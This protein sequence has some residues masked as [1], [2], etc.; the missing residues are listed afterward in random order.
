MTDCTTEEGGFIPVKKRRRNSQG[1]QSSGDTVITSP[2]TLHGLTVVLKPTDPT[3]KISKLNALKLTETLQGFAPDGVIQIRPNHR[4]NIL[5]LDTRN[6]ESTKA[7][8]LL[9]RI[10]TIEVQAYEPRKGEFAVG[11]I[12]DVDGDITDA[13]L[14]AS[15]RSTAPVSHVRRL[16]KSQVVKVDFATPDIPEYLTIGYIRYKVHPYIQKP[17]QCTNCFRFGH[18]RY[19]CIKPTCC[20]F[21]GGHHDRSQCAAA[22]P[23]CVNCGKAHESTSL[24]CTIYITAKEV[25]DYRSRHNVDYFTAKNAVASSSNASSVSPVRQS[26]TPLDYAN[27]FPPLPSSTVTAP[28]QPASTP[29]SKATAAAGAAGPPPAP[30][31]WRTVQLDSASQSAPR[32]NSALASKTPGTTGAAGSLQTPLLQRTVDRDTASKFVPPH[33]SPTPA[34]SVPQAATNGNDSSA[35][36]GIWHIISVVMQV[37]RRVLSSSESSVAKLALQIIDMLSPLLSLP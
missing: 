17:L 36:T 33:N 2:T 6:V 35:A 25:S 28:Q 1:S 26:S 30:L 31:A 34:M 22:E 5:A 7:L 27:S 24:D 20:A 12:R 10:G 8:L 13:Q 14:K 32:R 19:A 15:L 16:G 29:A 18:V 3:N 11:T 21:C 37:I 4:L 9:K 23:L